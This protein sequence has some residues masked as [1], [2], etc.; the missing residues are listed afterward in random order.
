M[1]LFDGESAQ[2]GAQVAFEG[3]K[4]RQLDFL[5]SFAEKLLRGRPQ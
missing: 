5:G 2:D 4:D 1:Y 3:L